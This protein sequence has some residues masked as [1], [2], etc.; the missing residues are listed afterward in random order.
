MS[1]G[2]A[3]LCSGTTAAQCT[4]VTRSTPSNAGSCTAPRSKATRGPCDALVQR[5]KDGPAY[6]PPNVP[7]PLCGWGQHLDG[8]PAH[9]S[10][11]R[12]EQTWPDVFSVRL[13]L[14]VVPADRWLF[15]R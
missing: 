8:R 2:L 9:Q 6:H 14:R 15:R 3:T 12:L 5:L 7:D 4:A 11:P 10:G 1:G 13:S